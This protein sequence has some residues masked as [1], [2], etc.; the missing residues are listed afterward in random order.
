M[1]GCNEKRR[2]RGELEYPESDVVASNGEPFR[3]SVF[4]A[5]FCSTAHELKYEHLK[6]EADDAAR[7]AE[8]SREARKYWPECDG[9]PY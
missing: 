4:G 1:P 7:A 2:E 5:K 8:E 6:A 3:V 9:P